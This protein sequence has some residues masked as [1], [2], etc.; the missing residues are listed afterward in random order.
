MKPCGHLRAEGAARTT[1]PIRLNGWSV[2]MNNNPKRSPRADVGPVHGDSKRAV[3]KPAA[4]RG[5]TR[6]RSSRADDEGGDGSQGGLPRAPLRVTIHPLHGPTE[7]VDVT[8]ALVGAVA[9]VLWKL[10][11]GNDPV[12][13]LEATVLLERAMRSCGTER[14][15]SGAS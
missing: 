3:S 11:G 6:R 5:K 7:G 15:P 1:C 10:Q 4:G 9:L 12:N 14:K 2:Q 13:R 8:D